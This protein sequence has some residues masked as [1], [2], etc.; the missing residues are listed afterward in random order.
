M[1]TIEYAKT[2]KTWTALLA[3]TGVFWIIGFS[4]YCAKLDNTVFAGQPFYMELIDTHDA[5][6]GR[7]YP[8]IMLCPGDATNE[9]DDANL[10]D[11]TCSAC[12]LTGTNSSDFDVCG[13]QTDLVPVFD[14]VHSNCWTINFGDP[15][16]VNGH[17]GG[18]INC[19]W[20]YSKTERSRL[21]LLDQQWPVLWK[22]NKPL[23]PN[24]FV[25]RTMLMNTRSL[26]E[27]SREEYLFKEKH[28]KH[29]EYSYSLM[30]GETYGIDTTGKDYDSS[31]MVYYGNFI[32]RRFTQSVSDITTS[33]DF[34]YWIGFL[35]GL[36][37]FCYVAHS[38][39]YGATALALGWQEDDEYKH[40]LVQ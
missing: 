39:C 3:V 15:I 11:V 33:Y 13:E 6:L 23:L 14:Y 4:Y 8:A 19:T 22:N 31:M 38:F 24:G 9:G 36:T 5:K 16:A 34:W 28:D 37:F 21:Y 7:N 10:T 1:Q 12:N 40:Q 17:D 32:D 35:G 27:I 20:K 25:Q 18:F 26:I 29:T 2:H 30:D